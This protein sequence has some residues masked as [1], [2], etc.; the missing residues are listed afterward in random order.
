MVV[1]ESQPEYP[2]TQPKYHFGQWLLD[3]TEDAHGLVYSMAFVLDAGWE[4][5]LYYPDLGIVGREIQEDGLQPIVSVP[6]N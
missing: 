3:V 2:I 6:S 4:Y 5:G 1:I